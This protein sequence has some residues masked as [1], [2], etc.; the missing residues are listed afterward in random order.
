M[1]IARRLVTGAAIA[2]LAGAGFPA[3]AEVSAQ[4]DAT[5][6]YLRTV[7]SSNASAKSFKIWSVNRLRFGNWPLNP[8]GDASGDLWP[9]IAESPVSQRWPW[10]VWSH[11]NGVDFDLVWSRWTGKGWM[12]ITSVDAAPDSRDALD[13][14]VSFDVTG[15]PHMAWVSSGTTG[16]D[17]V[18]LSVFLASRWM[19]PFLVSD[20]SEDALNPEIVVDPDGAIE[21]SYDTPAGHMTRTVRFVHPSTITDDI[22]P[23]NTFTITKIT[24][25]P[26]LHR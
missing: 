24:M 20:P 7:V 12:T 6:T 19:A 11:F 3:R 2:V 14:R 21:V 15:R 26:L 17:H 25:S 9:V 8:Y 13:P 18:Y 4:T 1:N 23:F 5:G 22:T 16:P 10:V